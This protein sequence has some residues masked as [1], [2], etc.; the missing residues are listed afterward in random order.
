MLL[1]RLSTD[2]PSSAEHLLY[3]IY[4][5]ET[6]WWKKQL[7][8]IKST[9]VSAPGPSFFSFPL[10]TLAE[11]VTFQDNFL[12][13]CWYLILHTLS[14]CPQDLAL[15]SIILPQPPFLPHFPQ[16]T[17]K[18]IQTH[19]LPSRHQTP[20]ATAFLTSQPPFPYSFNNPLLSP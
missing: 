20:L 13:L 17:I 2:Y 7:P 16:P 10:I 12:H 1:S 8:T 15:L 11:H 5:I 3:F 6:T 14:S 4:K 18:Q 19:A 9:N